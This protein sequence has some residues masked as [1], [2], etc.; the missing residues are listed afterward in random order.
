MT[1]ISVRCPYC[2]SNQ[3]VKRGKTR[4]GTRV[5]CAKIL[6]VPRRAFCWSTAIGGDCLR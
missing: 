3:I 2:H 5:I 6:R 4:R 1:F